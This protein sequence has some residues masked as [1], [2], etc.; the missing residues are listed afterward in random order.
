VPVGLGWRC[1]S[2]WAVLVVVSG[3][4][5]LP[6]VA[7][8][9][10][11]ELVDDTLPRQ[12]YHA[13]AESGLSLGEGEALVAR[14]A[15]AAASG[16]ARATA[17]AVEEFGVGAVAVVGGGRNIPDAF[18]RVLHSHALLHAAEG[19]LYEE[20][21]VEAAAR[22]GLPVELVGAKNLVVDPAVDTA[23]KGLG[24]PWQKDHKLA[25]SAALASVARLSR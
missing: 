4:V 2:G 22:C 21:C 13:A 11:V 5:P 17:A 9:R 3:P 1:H 10:R 18:E 14:V 7:C 6:T 8:R 12:P 16:A 25:A 23:G 20:A 19:K 24:P 15:E